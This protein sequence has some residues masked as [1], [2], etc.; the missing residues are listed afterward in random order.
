M[1][2]LEYVRIGDVKQPNRGTSQSAGL[3]FFIP[4][5]FTEIYLEPNKDIL[6]PSGIHVKFPPG[7]ALIAKN[8]S[9]ISSKLK[10]IIGAAVIDADYHGQV[11]IH[12]MNVGTEKVLLSPGMKITQFLLMPIEIPE[13]IEKNS[14]DEMY[15][16]ISER[17]TG[18]FGS[19]GI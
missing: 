9:G 1:T 14:L 17:G 4:N 6:I 19:T 3:D 16:E 12:I 13:L 5:D 8:K 7:F 15:Q 2:Q 11:H 18:G 10:L